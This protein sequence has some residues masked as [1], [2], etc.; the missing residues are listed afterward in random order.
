LTLD[1]ICFD[2]RKL[3]GR[4][5]IRGLSIP[6]PT[7]IRCV[8]AGKSVPEILTAYPGLEAE[9]IRQALEYAARLAEESWL[10]GWP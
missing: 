9:D 8:A 5:Y 1:R 6:V 7:V 3:E 2:P 4:P 10:P